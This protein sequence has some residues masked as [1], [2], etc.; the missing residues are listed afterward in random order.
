MPHQ[1][2]Q[3]FLVSSELGIQWILAQQRADGSFCDPAD[4]IG[5]YYKVPYALSLTGHNLA[6]QRLAEWIAGHHFTAQGDFRAPNRKAIEPFHENWPVYANAWLIQGLHRLGRWDLS[7]GGAK[8]LLG[9][10]GSA[11]GFYAMEGENRFFEPVCTAWGGLAALTTG[12]LEAACR[13][14][15]LLV[16]L[17]RAQPD[18]GRFYFR[19]DIEGGLMT[20]VPAE[21]ELLY[22]VDAARQG[23]IYYNPGIAL[24]LLAHLYRA[25]REERYLQAANELFSFA[26]HCAEDVYSFPPSGRLG[27]GC[28]LLYAITGSPEARRAALQVGEYLV[29]TQTAEG[30]WR[31]PATGPYA[32]MKDRDGFEVHL[33][34]AAEFST[35]L[36][37]IAAHIG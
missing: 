14:G 16:R 23:Q 32:A 15:D 4:G 19:M 9:Y 27:L 29:E 34:V 2:I 8:Y 7:L 18:A 28:A 21:A 12:Y 33:D 1:I 37:E 5:G 25:T 35:F 22:Y 20:Q 36:A 30:F 11:G 13:A 17:V 3:Q 31:L 26:E 10:Q 6:A 24:I